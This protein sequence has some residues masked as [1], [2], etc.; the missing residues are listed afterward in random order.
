MKKILPLLLI[1]LI[2]LQTRAQSAKDFMTGVN[3][4]LIKSSN[5]GYFEKVQASAELNYF[6][7]RK[8]T[9]TGGIEWWTS[10]NQVSLIIGT[11]WYPISDAFLRLR[12]LVGANELSVG[13]GW[14]KPL[15][16][17]MKFEAMGD[18]Y[19]RGDIAIRAGLVYLFRRNVE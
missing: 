14:A 8:F 5:D 16:V 7:S 6:I 15:N 13:G 11:R 17:N 4:D 1:A 9:A 19:F 2:S 10:N 18:V 12:G 3:V